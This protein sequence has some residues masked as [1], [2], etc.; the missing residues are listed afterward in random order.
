ML[1][2]RH[3][4]IALVLWKGDT[5]PVRRSIHGYR[6][7]YAAAE[8]ADPNLIVLAQSVTASAFDEISELLAR[9]DRPSAIIV[10]GTHMLNSALRAIAVRRLNVPDDLSVIAI[11]DTDLAR[12]YEPAVSVLMI[13]LAEAAQRL[14]HLL[15]NRIAMPQSAFRRERIAL[16]Y[17]ER[18]SVAPLSKATQV[19][20]AMQVAPCT[21]PPKGRPKGD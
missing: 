7:A 4:R 2:L 8:L 16:H 5:R 15:L 6:A 14:A 17:I 11:G 9:P 12:E 19:R 1:A 18:T 10:Q 13:D 3:C 20:P 21:R